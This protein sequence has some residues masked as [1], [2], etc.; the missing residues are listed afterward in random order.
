MWFGRDHMWFSAETVLQKYKLFG[1][2]AVP[3]ISKY[4]I[5]SSVEIRMLCVRPIRSLEKN[6]GAFAIFWFCFGHPA[7]FRILVP[8]TRN[9]MS[10]FVFVDSKAIRFPVVWVS[11]TR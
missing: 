10:S 6:C 11:K 5:S 7:D 1:R 9:N 4:F 2:K 8:V 3:T